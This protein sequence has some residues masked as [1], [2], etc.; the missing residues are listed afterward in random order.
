MPWKELSAPAMR[1]RVE[2]VRSGCERAWARKATL[3][4]EELLV[5]EFVG[6][7]GEGAVAVVETVRS[8]A[9]LPVGGGDWEIRQ[10]A[11]WRGGGSRRLGRCAT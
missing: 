6:A 4:G 3:A 10:L 2:S 7:T 5:P 1:S 8:S 11:K 9:T